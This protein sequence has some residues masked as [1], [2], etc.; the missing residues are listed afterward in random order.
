MQG[1]IRFCV[2]QNLKLVKLSFP[3]PCASP[4]MLEGEVVPGIINP[5]FAQNINLLNE[6]HGDGLFNEPLLR[7]EGIIPNKLCKTMK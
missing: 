3:P 2:V 1:H 4:V 7:H 6:D 5:E